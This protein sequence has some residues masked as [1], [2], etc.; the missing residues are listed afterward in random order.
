MDKG[1]TLALPKKGDLGIIKNYRGITLTVITAKFYNALLLNHIRPEVKK[2][3]R[4][5]QNGF[6]RNRSTTS[7][8]VTIR[9]IIEQV[10]AKNFVAT[11]L[12]VDFFKAFDSIHRGKIEQI[13]LE[14]DL[15]K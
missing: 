7:L 14:Y 15:P 5:N 3:L 6:R 13:L 9:R 1:C 4:K 10:R 8:I 11:I 12:F 2:V